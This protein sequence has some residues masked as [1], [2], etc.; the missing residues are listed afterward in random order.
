MGLSVNGKRVYRIMKKLSALPKR[1]SYHS[2]RGQVGKAC[3]I[4][5]LARKKDGKG[6]ICI[7]ER[8]LAAAKPYEKLGTDVTQF[9]TKFGKLYLS[10]VIDFYTREAL[11]YDISEHPD[12]A[13]IRRM[14][15]RLFEAHGEVFSGAILRSDQ[16]YQYQMKAYQELLK[17]HGIRQSMSRKG[18]CLDNSPTENFFGRLKT[19]MF[20]DDEYGLQ[21]LDDLR[22]RIEKY[23]EYYNKTRIVVRLGD[24]PANIRGG[25]LMQ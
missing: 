11:A 4:L 25:M 6:G 23:I 7:Y 8:Q 9:V 5:P 10:P 15:G 14:M 22:H 1:R 20:Y 16:G 12:Y 13:Q 19:E 24:S 17:R 3:E 21:S 18:N 2:Y